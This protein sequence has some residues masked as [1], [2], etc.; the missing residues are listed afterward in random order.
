MNLKKLFE[1][2]NKE[3]FHTNIENKTKENENYRE[4][5]FTTTNLQLVLMSLGPKEE[6]GEEIH[7]F[8]SQFIRIDKGSGKAIIGDKTYQLKDGD[9]IVIPAGVKH[10][11]IAG[12]GGIKLYAIYAPPEHEPNTIH[13]TKEEEK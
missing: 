8:G 13:P 6:I 1:Q 12:S 10:N 2:E 3:G 7:K 4:V 9:A 5:L 11:V